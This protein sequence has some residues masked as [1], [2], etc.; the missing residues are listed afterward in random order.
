MHIYHVLLELIWI[1]SHPASL[2]RV[3]TSL[4]DA[5]KDS[6]NA[7]DK[8]SKSGSDEY[9]DSV[10]DE[11]CGVIENLIGSAFVTCQAEITAVVSHAIRIH[12]AAKNAGHILSSS[13]GTKRG[14]MAV[15]SPLVGQTKYTQIQVINAFANYF[16]HGDEWDTTWDKL[17]NREKQTADVILAMGGAEFSTG[18]LRKGAEALG[19]N[20]DELHLLAECVQKWSS[21][22][23]TTPTRTNS[24][25]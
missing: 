6:G 11:E 19:V 3:M 14:I 15:G 16:K 10:I 20:Y 21:L 22:R 13:D 17:P 1:R 18:N 8:A 25:A 4:G 2:Y 12:D 7:I 5:V 9:L 24:R 23:F